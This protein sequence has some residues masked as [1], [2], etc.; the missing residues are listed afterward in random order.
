MDEKESELLAKI[1]E[2]GSSRMSLI[3]ALTGLTPEEIEEL[4]GL[5]PE[6]RDYE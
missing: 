4:G 5:G 1:A 3:C 6:D 2:I